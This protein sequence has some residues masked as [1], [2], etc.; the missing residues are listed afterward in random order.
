MRILTVIPISRGIS[1]DTLTYFSKE[2]AAPG[3][4]VSIPIRGRKSFGLVVESAPAEEM[5]TELK[6]LSYS[7]RKIDDI[8][9]QAFV[10]EDF[11]AA[12]K[13]IAD[14]NA[15]SL[16]AT[17]SA[18]LP[19]HI[20]EAMGELPLPELKKPDGTFFETLLL[21][22]SDE[23]RYAAY[24]SLIREEFAKGR[25]IMFILP[26]TED[27]LSAKAVLE[28]GI[29]KY[30]HVL[31]AGLPKKEIVGLWRSISEEVHPVVVVTT[32]SFLALPV[33]NLGS[34]VLEKESSRGYKMQARPFIDI[35][36]AAEAVAKE[37]GV[38]LILGDTLLR[39]ET[40]WELK[41]QKKNSYSE[42]SPLKFRFLSPARADIE[43]MRVPADAKTK[44]FSLFGEK[45]R[46]TLAEAVE[47]NENTF[48]FC[49]RKG[50]SPVTVCSD[51]GTVVVCRN[52]NAPVVLYRR[53]EMSASSKNNLF[54]CHHCGERRDAGELC[55][56]CKSWRLNPLG[57]GTERVAEE[58]R[59]LFPKASVSIMDKD[60][61]RNHKQAVRTR[62]AF[63]ESPGGILVGTEMA[64]PY[65]NRKIE[66]AA[67][68]SMDS[69]F[70][71]PDF[72]I[73]EKIFHILLDLRALAEKRVV[74]QTR[75]ER[76][77]IFEEAIKGNLID[78]YRDEIEERKAIGYPPFATYVKI[79]LEGEKARIKKE[80]EEI[81]QFL[82]PYVLNVF[83]AWNPGSA[84]AYTVHGLISLPK[85]AWVDPELL[86]KLRS[87]PP[88]CAVKIDPNTLL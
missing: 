59:K 6:S 45:L 31:H 50:L 20:L 2:D 34:V 15:A 12:S 72:R 29:E 14:Y 66:N 62:D 82:L 37:L 77:E 64:L 46:K 3:S 7:I 9:S 41:S 5:K 52:C 35:R 84:K 74:V 28:K 63:Y 39:V 27:L 58:A 57:I 25:S 85:E 51:C 33:Q 49:G 53:K 83:D 36:Q 48:L 26:T 11:I 22:S 60:N 56:H 81:R 88:Q 47:N 78:F 73:N 70:A 38:R 8:H 4:L 18:L 32:G 44:E 30:A 19:K 61:I 68:V 67:V 17:L 24:K 13:K 65:L 40:I 43:S 80:M 16:G 10:P 55:A 76:T 86:G 75:Q 1:K 42:F 21:Q 23:E 87:L 79:S 54:V 71:I 69:Y